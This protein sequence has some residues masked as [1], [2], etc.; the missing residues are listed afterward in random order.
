MFLGLDWSSWAG[1]VSA[2]RP[3]SLGVKIEEQGRTTARAMGIPYA[4]IDM[5]YVYTDILKL[6]MM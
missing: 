5:M 2:S 1:E 3:G 6:C 4:S